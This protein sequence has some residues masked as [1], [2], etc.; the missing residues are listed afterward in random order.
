MGICCVTRKETKEN[1]L[2]KSPQ[3]KN[4]MPDFIEGSDLKQTVS[5]DYIASTEKSKENKEF[6]LKKNNTISVFC[7][8]NSSFL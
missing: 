7:F 5:V 3:E 4:I 2:G 1:S 6:P 8:I